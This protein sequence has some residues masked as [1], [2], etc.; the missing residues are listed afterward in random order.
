MH[1]GHGRDSDLDNLVLLKSQYP[2]RSGEHG[3]S[4]NSS[5]WDDN[6]GPV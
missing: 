1:W 2:R 4:D 6:F 3:W 5:R